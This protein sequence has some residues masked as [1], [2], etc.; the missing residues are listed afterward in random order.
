MTVAIKRKNGDLI[1]FDAVLQF[2]R[3]YSASVTQHPIESG[4]VITDHTIL[5]NPIIQLSGVISDADFNLA[6][7]I[8]TQSDAD[9]FKITNKQFVNNAPVNTKVTITEQNTLGRFLPESVGQFLP[10]PTISV[11]VPASSKPK[12]AE[13]LQDDIRSMWQS[14]EEF[15]LISFRGSTIEDTFDNCIITSL[16][17]TE[18]PDGGD[19]LYPNLTIERV[20]Y[21][22]SA[23]VKIPQDVQ[24]SVKEQAS[25][26]QG[27]GRKAGETTTRVA[28]AGDGANGP[29]DHSKRASDKSILRG[30]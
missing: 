16:D 5:D 27:K 30:G 28:K 25:P 26:N 23:N 17:F 1:W 10:V 9:N 29:T 24:D 22:K 14:R 18:T 11:E 2:S 15:E 12:S 4:G 8:I 6:R 13:M 20:T 21:V 3:Q 19:A 7:P